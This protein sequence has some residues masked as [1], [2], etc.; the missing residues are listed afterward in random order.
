MRIGIILTGDYTWAGGLY[1]SLG[2]VRLL[3]R[4]PVEKNLT[5]VVIVNANTPADVLSQVPKQNTEIVYLD[6]KPWLYRLWHRILGDRFSADIKA[7]R[8]DVLYPL[9][10][11]H[12]SHRHLNCRA[13]YWIY[14]LQ[15]KFLPDL[16]T[17][18]ERKK[19]DDTFLQMANHAKEIVFSSHD[20][21][22]H[23]ERFYAQSKAVRHVYNF[24]SLIKIDGT[25][26]IPKNY[27]IVCNQFWP[28]KN[29]LVVLKALKILKA[30]GENPFVVFT[31]KHDDLQNANY[32]Q[33]L[34]KFIAENHLSSQIQLTGFLPR[35]TQ[36]AMMEGSLAVI[37]PS[38]FEGWSTVVEDAKALNKF[39][40]ASDIAVNREQIH[41]NVL[42]FEPTDAET[43]A[44]N[45]RLV[46]EGR[47]S[48]VAN[49]YNKNIERSVTDLC[50]LFGIKN[51]PENTRKGYL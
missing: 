23:F 15:H 34:K 37:Q 45:I 49:D 14:D 33:D 35:E 50:R 40:I 1:Y 48:V 7:L 16:F 47:V 28:H 20:S 10:A 21:L 29:H 31:G 38:L 41:H 22:G 12:P 17:R 24:I 9:I 13:I 18:E 6:H 25:A 46:S 42:F 36:T 27:F 26:A 32:V 3:Q 51:R 11:W 2:I 8:L 30:Q 43:L 19:R 4:A 44:N 5:V 39:L